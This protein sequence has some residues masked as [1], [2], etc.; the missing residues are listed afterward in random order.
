VIVDL[1]VVLSKA[2]TPDGLTLAGEH[3]LLPAG[4]GRLVIVHGYAEHRGRYRE[5]V[6]DLTNAGYECHLPDLR[7]HGDSE[8]P[9]GH[10]PR[11]ADYAADL[12]LFLAEVRKVSTSPA[13]LLLL[14][15]SLGGLIALDFVRRRPEVFA[16]AA[17]SS[18]FL[19]PALA[20]P[21]LKR[22]FLPLVARLLPTLAVDSGLSA[23]WLSHD[24][25][26][27]RAY[28]SDPRVFSTVTLGW[29]TAATEAQRQVF[30][31][32]PGIRLPILV[33]VG[34]ADRIAEPGRTRDFYA[35]LGSEE[36]K[37][38]VYPG[39]FHEVFNEVERARVVADLLG[40]LGERT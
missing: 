23:D 13:P 26:V 1:Q 27:V 39:F 3:H 4:R 17:V 31:G 20:I 2:R 6:A 36:K 5:L 37:L 9:R 24:P 22:T 19:A 10:V 15:H 40:W 33:L 21:F 16:A 14:G 32:A 30:D 25:E 34:D 29:F 11:F 28:A 12:G 18:P 7:G 8:G 35:R 38:V